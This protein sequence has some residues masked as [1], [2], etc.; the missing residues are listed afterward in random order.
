MKFPYLNVQMWDKDILKYDDLIAEK[1]IDL[2]REFFKA[3]Q[4]G[5]EVA[6]DPKR[7]L[8]KNKK[9]K[10]KG[11]KEG[12]GVDTGAGKKGTDNAEP[13]EEKAAGTENGE[14]LFFL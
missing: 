3:F 6:Y 10:K 11:K 12:K 4:K 9:K 13:L 8:R 14:F 2:K 1:I 5:T 7:T